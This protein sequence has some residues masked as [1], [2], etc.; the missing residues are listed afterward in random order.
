VGCTGGDIGIWFV[1]RCALIAATI[2]AMPLPN[3]ANAGMSSH[4]APKP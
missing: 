3:K 1:T 2:R 4:I